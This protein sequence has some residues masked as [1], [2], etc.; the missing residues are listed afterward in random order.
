MTIV[1]T[2]LNYHSA[3]QWVFL[4]SFPILFLN[5]KKVF[6]YKNALE[7]YPE[8]PRLSMASLIFALTFGIGLLL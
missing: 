1:Y 4:L 8:L 6:T 7:L 2:L 3:W 5:L